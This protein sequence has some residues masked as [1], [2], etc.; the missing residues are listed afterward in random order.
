MLGT[1]QPFSGQPPWGLRETDHPFFTFVHSWQ[2]WFFLSIIYHIKPSNRPI[3]YQK[4]HIENYQFFSTKSWATQQHPN[5]NEPLIDPT[6]TDQLCDRSN[7]RSNRWPT[8]SNRP[9]GDRCSVINSQRPIRVANRFNGPIHCDRTGSIKNGRFTA[10]D[11]QKSAVA[12]ATTDL[13]WQLTQQRPTKGDRLAASKSTATKRS[14]QHLATVGQLRTA[15]LFVL[16]PE[17]FWGNLSWDPWVL[18]SNILI[19]KLTGL[20]KTFSNKR[21]TPDQA[22]VGFL[23][24]RKAKFSAEPSTN[25]LGERKEVETRKPISQPSPQPI[26]LGE[27]GGRHNRCLGFRVY[28]LLTEFTATYPWKRGCRSLL[29]TFRLGTF[30]KVH[31]DVS[32][33]NRRGASIKNLDGAIWHCV[34]WDFAYMDF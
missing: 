7:N 23:E 32:I 12:V 4:A 10:I 2:V 14:G 20:E 3:S 27:R 31:S 11:Q 15:A 29:W 28:G 21:L 26:C 24:S 18:Q 34:T 16:V 25:L 6:A 5:H 17:T 9:T 8:Q 30:N 19:L 13:R 1:F 33:G 22:A